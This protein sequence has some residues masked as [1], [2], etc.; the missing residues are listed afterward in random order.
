MNRRRFLNLF[1]PRARGN[2]VGQVFDLTHCA[3]SDARTL[4]SG[5]RPDLPEPANFV[6]A[7]NDRKPLWPIASLALLTGLNLLDY[8]D[9]QILASVL[10]LVRKELKSFIQ[11]ASLPS[12]ESTTADPS[13]QQP[14]Q[15]SPGESDKS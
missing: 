14:S 4:G 10:P 15:E 6:S 13:T 1:K 2:E 7:I 12:P 9:R 11:K 8:L 3:A 5:R